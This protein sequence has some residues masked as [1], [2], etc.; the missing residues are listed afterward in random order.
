MT[1]RLRLSPKKP[2]KR[3]LHLFK[4]KTCPLQVKF[5]NTQK[6]PKQI[7]KQLRFLSVRI[8]HTVQNSFL[9]EQQCF[10]ASNWVHPI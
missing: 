7:C 6:V 8:S 9:E 2:Q 4:Y 1:S 5:T 10:N 3:S